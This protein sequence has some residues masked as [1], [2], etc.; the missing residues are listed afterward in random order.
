MRRRTA[1]RR[2]AGLGLIP[3]AGCTRDFDGHQEPSTFPGTGASPPTIRGEPSFQVHERNPTDEEDQAGSATVVFDDRGGRA[4][5]STVVVEGRII[6]TEGCSTAVLDAATYDAAADELRVNVATRRATD[7]GDVCTQP[8]MEIDYTA[9]IEFD[10]GLP[11]TVV[12]V[13]HVQS[14]SETV[15]TATR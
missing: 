12:V 1:V 11:G 4:D 13:H 10:G 15:T 2:T 9:G 14:G 7:A 3:I 8:L 5:P 6:G